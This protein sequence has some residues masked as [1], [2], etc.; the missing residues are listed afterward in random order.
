[1]L[2]I[3]E[4][5]QHGVPIPSLAVLKCVLP[6]KTCD[7]FA[8]PFGACIKEREPDRIFRGERT[9]LK[10]EGRRLANHPK[11]RLAVGG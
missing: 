5:K 1:M 11:G 8:P 4:R 7:L 6:Q 9:R 3:W 10:F 2:L